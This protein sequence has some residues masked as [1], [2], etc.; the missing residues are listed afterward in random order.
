MEEQTHSS[1]VF[2]EASFHKQNDL[3]SSI[4]IKNVAEISIDEIVNPSGNHSDSASVRQEE[5][6]NFITLFEPKIGMN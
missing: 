5:K 2:E 3:T 1:M 6:L 4:D